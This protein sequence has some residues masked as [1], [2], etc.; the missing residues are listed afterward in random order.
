MTYRFIHILYIML[1]YFL[2]NKYK[3]LYCSLQYAH[4]GTWLTLV[5]NWRSFKWKN[6]VSEIHSWSREFVFRQKFM[7]KY[8]SSTFPSRDVCI[9]F[10]EKT[11]RDMR[12]WF[13]LYKEIIRHLNVECFESAVPAIIL[14]NPMRPLSLETK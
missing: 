9:Y 10:R 1:I 13:Y 2:I 12:C 6:R 7:I 5:K 14:S 4:T 3:L 8:K 11:W